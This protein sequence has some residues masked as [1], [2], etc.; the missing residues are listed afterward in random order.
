MLSSILPLLLFAT[1]I[2]FEDQLVSLTRVAKGAATALG[3]DMGDAMDRLI[4][5][6]A[7][8]EPEI[9]DELG[10]MVRLDDAT[11]K[12]ADSVNKS[13]SELTQFEKIRSRFRD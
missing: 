11:K 3:R 5:G 7:K 4:R 9:L 12:Y 2:L 13:A 6:A 8:L 1:H 10:I